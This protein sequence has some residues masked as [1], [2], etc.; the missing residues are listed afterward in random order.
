MLYRYF[1]IRRLI[2]PSGC[3]SDTL[4]GQFDELSSEEAKGCFKRAA[5][6]LKENESVL[7]YWVDAHSALRIVDEVKH[8]AEFSE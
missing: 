6:E 7:L 4:V 8:G 3:S 2:L 5:E 1:V